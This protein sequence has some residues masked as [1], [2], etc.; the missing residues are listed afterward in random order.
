M[1]KPS[2]PKSEDRDRSPERK[3]TVD[4]SPEKKPTQAQSERQS[5]EVT[6]EEFD[7]LLTEWL[8]PVRELAKTADCDPVEL[9]EV[10][11]VFCCEQQTKISY[12]IAVAAVAEHTFDNNYAGDALQF[13]VEPVL[14]GRNRNP[15]I[16]EQFWSEIPSL[17][18]K[19]SL[20]RIEFWSVLQLHKTHR[21]SFLFLNDHG[22]CVAKDHDPTK[23]YGESYYPSMPKILFTPTPL[24]LSLCLRRQKERDNDPDEEKLAL[25]ALEELNLVLVKLLPSI[26]DGG[27]FT[28]P[29]LNGKNPLADRIRAAEPKLKLTDNTIE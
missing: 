13:L 23:N 3:P 17:I 28:L 21:Q 15:K 19:L 7:K 22:V 24:S 6:V 9:A 4:R 25:A 8:G 11:S 16:S 1:S 2:K 18:E 27:S 10:V 26:L 14:Y 29:L 5:F 20:K 12:P